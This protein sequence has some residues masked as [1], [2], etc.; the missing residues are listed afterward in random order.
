MRF[1]RAKQRRKVALLYAKYH[2]EL[3]EICKNTR[4]LNFA[5]SLPLPRDGFA[6]HLACIPVQRNK[7]ANT[8][9][10]EARVITKEPF[11]FGLRKIHRVH[12]RSPYERRKTTAAV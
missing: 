9:T 2:A 6:R 7:R 4:L 8:R 11:A 10:S 12:T 3:R 1:M 5:F